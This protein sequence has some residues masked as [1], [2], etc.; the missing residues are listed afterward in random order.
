LSGN[1]KSSTVYDHVLQLACS[2]YLPVDTTQI[3]TGVVPVAG[4]PF[5]FTSPKPVGQQL[6]EVDGGG[7]PGYDHCWARQ[8]GPVPAAG[9]GLAPIAVLTDPSSGRTMRVSTDAAGVQLYTGN[10]LSKAAGDA[11]F[12]QHG[13]LC[14]ETE[15]YP[16]AVN[17]TAK[18]FPDII[19]R[20]G[21]T[22]KHVA[23]HKFEW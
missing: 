17:Q 23:I 16:D 11:P 14:L 22:Y 10:F 4:T 13:A 20:P 21:A 8:G 15:A 3:P 7:E 18:G 12:T 1:F 19:L 9:L 2:H 5:D 6:K